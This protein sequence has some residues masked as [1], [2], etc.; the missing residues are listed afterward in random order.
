MNIE[1]PHSSEKHEEFDISVTEDEGW[2]TIRISCA[3]L[4]VSVMHEYTDTIKEIIYEE[5]LPYP[6]QD[7]Q[8]YSQEGK[9]KLLIQMC[10][11]VDLDDRPLTVERVRALFSSQNLIHR[12]KLMKEDEKRQRL[13]ENQG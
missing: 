4:D 2:F 13:K 12:R 6:A 3:P 8:F 5:R 9:T 7:V 11:S 10:S 1:F